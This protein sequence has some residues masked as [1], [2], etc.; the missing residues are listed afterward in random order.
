MNQLLQ[1]LGTLAFGDEHHYIIYKRSID[2]LRIGT[3]PTTGTT[4]VKSDYGKDLIDL[5]S[6]PSK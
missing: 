4:S 6:A 2:N 1:C 5:P 3:H